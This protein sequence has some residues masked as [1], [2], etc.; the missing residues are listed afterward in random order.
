MKRFMGKSKAVKGKSR[1]SLTSKKLDNAAQ[2][3][4]LTA[5]M[6]IKSSFALSAAFVLSLSTALCDGPFPGET[7]TMDESG[8]GIYSGPLIAG[9]SNGRLAQDPVS[10]MVTLCYP[11]G[12][13]PVVPGDVLLSESATAV[14]PSD[15]IRFGV[16]ITSTSTNYVMYF[17]SDL[18]AGEPNPDLAD[19]GIPPY[20]NP[21]IRL[22]T[23]PD[24]NNGAFYQTTAGMPGFDTSGTF[25]DLTYHFLSDVPEPGSLAL[26]LSGMAIY[27]LRKLRRQ[28]SKPSH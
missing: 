23:G 6:T 10:G 7:F 17:F 8:Y 12:F 19:V 3:R 28:D 27:G 4:R 18:E 22:E 1:F 5:Y 26:L 24:G 13:G 21:V 25:P 20:S 2:S 14:V 15:L 11:L 16:E 9:Y